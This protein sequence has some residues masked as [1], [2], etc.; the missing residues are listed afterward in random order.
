MNAPTNVQ[1]IDY[2]GLPAFALVPYQDYLELVKHKQT[3]VTRDLIPHEVVSYMIDNNA[4]A[5]KAWRE[6]K[7]LTQAQIAERLGITQSAYAQMETSDKIR[8]QTKQKIADALGVS[9]DQL[10]IT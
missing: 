6:F 4:T 9:F 2:N 10:D 1:I 5:A 3:D 7:G 8:K